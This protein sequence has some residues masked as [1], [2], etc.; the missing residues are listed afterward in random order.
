MT[1]PLSFRS[2]PPRP[3]LTITQ[4]LTWADAFHERFG[5]WPTRTD[6]DRGLPDTTWSAINTCLHVGLRGLNPGSSL[7]QLLLARRGRRHKGRLPRLTHTKI[8]RWADD[9]RTRTDQWPSQYSG[10]VLATTGET[11]GAL[12]VALNTGCRGLPGGSSLAQLLEA[13]RGARN[14]LTLPP[15]SQEQILVWT[16]AHLARTGQWP[17]QASGC[18][19]EAPGE[20]WAAVDSAL[21]KGRRG[22]PGGRSLA[23]LLHSQR[24]VRNI[25]ALPSLEC[26]EILIWAGTHQNRTGRWPTAKSGSIT[27]A[28]G[29]TWASV[30]AALWEGARG[31]PG[32]DSLARLLAR[33]CGVSMLC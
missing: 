26:W 9:H 32:G 8:L 7:A 33:R 29:E 6:K 18:I 25:A 28:P 30:D 19:A 3:A 21:G 14:H 13:K 5:R 1:R 27:E 2:A 20:T 4:I 17:R 31:L 16:D 12:N 10:P 23:R 11:W 24:G 15:F 22:L